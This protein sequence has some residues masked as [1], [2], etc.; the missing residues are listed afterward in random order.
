MPRVRRF[1]ADHPFLFFIRDP[2]SG[3]VLFLGRVAK[4]QDAWPGL[5][6]PG[7]AAPGRR[8]RA[9]PASPAGRARR[10]RR[11]LARAIAVRS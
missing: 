4:P 5:A 8:R 9:P 2:V 7:L 6:S 1:T 11:V 3:V 10:R